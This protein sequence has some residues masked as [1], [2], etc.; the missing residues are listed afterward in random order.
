MSTNYK[1]SQS[2]SNFGYNFDDFFVRREY[3]LGTTLWGWG[4]NSF[5]Q[6]G[7]NT[8]GTKSS[9]VQNVGYGTNWMKIGVASLTAYGIRNDGTLWSWGRGADGMLANNGTVDRSS[10][11]QTVSATTNWKDVF[12]GITTRSAAGLKTD[13]TLWLWGNNAY[14]QLGNNT[15]TYYSSP[16][17][18]V[19]GGNN[20]RTATAGGVTTAAIKTDGTLWTW[21]RG[22]NGALGDNTTT[23]K[24]SPVQTIAGGTTWR[25]VASAGIN[26]LGFLATKT[27]GTLWVWGDNSNGTLGLGDNTSR[28][29]PTKVGS[30][31]TW[32]QVSGGYRHTAA[33]KTDG[34][35]WTW[36][37]NDQGQLGTNTVTYYSS[38]VQTYAGGT[39]WKQVS[40]GGNGTIGFTAAIKTD[41]TLW[42]WGNNNNG[43]LGLGDT[44][45][46]SAPTQVG[47]NTNWSR[48][49]AGY[50]FTIALKF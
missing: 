27:D 38:P 19:A 20:W 45:V 42:T 39:N 22:N 31:T 48:V 44:S 26:V 7:D 47:T 5:G 37:W 2:G 21:G 23:S 28:S 34:T 1:I 6:V 12:T 25:S 49:Q 35:L 46:R 30:D 17:Q 14:G 10:P 4:Y 16:I 24:S 8:T 41:G 43:Q 3:I 50:N 9:P 33:I 29:S 40:A 13:G 36:G 32:K 11:G 18:T 15:R